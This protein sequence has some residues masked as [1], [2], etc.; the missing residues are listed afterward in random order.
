M[1]FF[2]DEL[3]GGFVWEKGDVDAFGWWDFFAT[4]FGVRA[5]F[6]KATIAATTAL[7]TVIASVAL[8]SIALVAVV[9]A[10]TVISVTRGK[11]AFLGFAEFLFR[12]SGFSARP[13][14]TECKLVE[15]AF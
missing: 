4:W 9:A 12:A 14:W 13:C 6:F 11:I 10:A 5:G 15:K 2:A 8:A 3:D 7:A 1:D